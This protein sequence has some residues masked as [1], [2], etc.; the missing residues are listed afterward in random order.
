MCLLNMC[1]AIQSPNE[2]TSLCYCYLFR[3]MTAMCIQTESVGQI[4]QLSPDL[5]RGERGVLLEDVVGNFSHEPVE[6][7]ALQSFLQGELFADVA[8]V[9]VAGQ[10]LTCVEVFLRSS[11][12]PCLNNASVTKRRLVNS[13]STA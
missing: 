1:A 6:T 8:R 10:G 4:F 2:I 5:I 13:S 11:V 9:H 12:E 7:L 3:R